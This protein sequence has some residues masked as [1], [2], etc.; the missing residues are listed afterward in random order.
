MKLFQTTL[1]LLCLAMTSFGSIAVK[2]M[3]GHATTEVVSVRPYIQ[4][5][6]EGTSPIDLSVHTIEY[7][8]FDE[9]VSA[10]DLTWELYHCALGNVYTMNFYDLDKVYEKDGRKA[11]IKCEITFISP[12]SL[13]AG[14]TLEMRHGIFPASWQH[15]FSQ[16]DDWSYVPSLHYIYNDNIVVRNYQTD[17]VVYGNP[18]EAMNPRPYAVAV[19]WLGEHEFAD[20]DSVAVREGDAFL[21]SGDRKSYVFYQDTW[22]L[23]SDVQNLSAYATKQYVDNATAN[24]PAGSMV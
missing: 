19:T 16:G 14:A 21:N 10:S 3:T 24:I 1:L 8:I 18:L 17:E 4:L 23:L 12:V 20:F 7:Y 2:H 22:T 11:N 5:I 13:N 9:S 15:T 6:N